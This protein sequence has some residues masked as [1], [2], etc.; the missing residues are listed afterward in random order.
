MKGLPCWLNGKRNPRPAVRTA[1]TGIW[2]SIKL[3]YATLWGRVP[4]SDSYK[5]LY[6][7]SCKA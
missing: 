5:D 1:G 3:G 2:V 7:L 4:F 6:I